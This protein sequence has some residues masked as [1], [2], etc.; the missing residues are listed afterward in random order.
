[1]R[2]GIALT[3]VLH[4]VVC[5]IIAGM[6]F[7]QGSQLPMPA[8][9]SGPYLGPSRW[10]GSFLSD[11]TI[12]P[13]AHVAYKRLGL[14]FSLDVPA[15]ELLSPFL[16]IDQL[17]PF[18]GSLLDTFPLDF[19]LNSADLL[20]GDVRLDAHLTGSV[21]VYGSV[22]A[23]IPRKVGVKA[24][25]GPAIGVLV[26]QSYSWTGSRLQWSQFE[27]GGSYTVNPSMALV[28]GI[29]WERT[30]VR[31]SDPEPIPTST[32][33]GFGLLPFGFFTSPVF[34]DGYGGDFRA[35]LC[36][37]FIGVNFR[38]PHAR[39]SLKIGPAATSLRLP[40]NLS[41]AGPYRA[42]S[43]TLGPIPILSFGRSDI[44]EQAAYTFKKAG[45]FLEGKVESDVRINESLNMT[46]W[47][48]GS[49]LRIRGNGSV[50][51]S[52]ESTTSVT[53]LGFPLLMIPTEYSASENG[54]STLTQYSLSLGMSG[55]LSF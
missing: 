29:R 41:H 51:L 13:S 48:E 31:F 33:L 19:K 38:S 40:L 39:C 30:T 3:G 49:W 14:N 5:L 32:N 8:A 16:G 55:S 54:A 46:F 20:I 6:A 42:F 18:F 21:G 44:S 11:V 24:G 15:N 7:A 45:L 53:V 22:S 37:P 17:F 27:I 34:L 9:A 2:R 23:S 50:D 26:P 4:V 35:L 10:F 12:V 36:T 1:M 47:A 52:G 43:L 25:V 28:A